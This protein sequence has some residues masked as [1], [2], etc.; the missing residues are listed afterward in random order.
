MN[1]P[2]AFEC[3]STEKKDLVHSLRIAANYTYRKGSWSLDKSF[4]WNRIV[5][6]NI[7]I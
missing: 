3:L 1:R 5:F 2:T 4:Y 6:N 7:A